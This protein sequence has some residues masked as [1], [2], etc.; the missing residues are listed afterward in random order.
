V[1]DFSLPMMNKLFYRHHVRSNEYVIFGSA[2]MYLHDL[3]DV[4][5]VHDLDVF[6]SPRVWGALLGDK[7][8]TG[9]TVETPRADDPPFLE[10]KI[11]TPI[12]F[13]YAWTER[14]RSWMDAGECFARA[15]T[16]TKPL[17]AV[18]WTHSEWRCIPLDLLRKHKALAHSHNL[19]SREHEKH[20]RDLVILDE[21]LA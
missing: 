5:S 16:V 13:F 20:Q 7:A 18:G 3:R 19:G 14:D 1:I 10:Y 15:E 6:V 8:A 4:G 17:D 21:A 12:H 9:M 11:D 2:V